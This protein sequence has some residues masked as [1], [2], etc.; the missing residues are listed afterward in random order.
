MLSL[1][2]SLSELDRL[3]ALQKAAAECYLSAVETAGHHVVETDE[4]MT[5]LFR[6]HLECLAGVGAETDLQCAD[7]HGGRFDHLRGAQS[8]RSGHGVLETAR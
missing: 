8:D 2:R 4:S 3:E 1:K 6:D 7:D 5:R